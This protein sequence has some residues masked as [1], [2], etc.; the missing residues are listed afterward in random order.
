MDYWVKGKLPESP[1]LGCGTVCCAYGVGTALKSWKKAGLGIQAKT[2]FNLYEPV[3]DARN[4]LG[5]SSDE[6]NR[7]TDPDSYDL[8]DWDTP[9]HPSEVA[10]RIYDALEA[11][12]VEC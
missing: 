3:D 7:I 1:M 10:G 12:K 11:G 5:L 4:I 9:I 8:E 6:W 2:R